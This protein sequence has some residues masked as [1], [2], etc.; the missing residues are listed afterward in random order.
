MGIQQ[1]RPDQRR[2][3]QPRPGQAGKKNDKVK[4][5]YKKISNDP[6]LQSY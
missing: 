6:T 5:F 2:P 3:G 1:S 4:S